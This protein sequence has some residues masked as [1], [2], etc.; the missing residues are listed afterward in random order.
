M[1][2]TEIGRHTIYELNR[3]LLSSKEAFVDSKS[4]KA[5]IDYMKNILEQ[6]TKL[7][8]Q[9]CDSINNCLLLLRNILHIP[10]VSCHH[11]CGGSHTNTIKNDVSHPIKNTSNSS[12]TTST[13]SNNAPANT[14]TNNTHT[15]IQAGHFH[16]NG[17][18]NCN[19]SLQ[20]QIIWH[21]FTQSIDKLLIHLMSCPQRAFWAVTMAQ[22]VALMYKDQHVSTLS[23]LLNMCFETT[24]SDSSEDNESNTSPPKS[25]DSSP[26]LTSEPT[27][28]SSDNGG[29]IRTFKLV[30]KES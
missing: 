29:E 1:S 24:L 9:Q 5:V 12:T 19:T 25:G 14:N 11:S 3:L 20:N 7:S 28:D 23:K 30:L 21:L 27:S 22:L 4:T 8:L 6:N 13:H 18:N 16:G 15:P 10:D 17:C 2:K 26:T